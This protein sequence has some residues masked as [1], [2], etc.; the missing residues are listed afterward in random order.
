MERVKKHRW[1]VTAVTVALITAVIVLVCYTSL[2]Q[3]KFI[4]SVGRLKVLKTG[5]NFCTGEQYSRC[6]PIGD[7]DNSDD[8]DYLTALAEREMEVHIEGVVETV[9]VQNQGC[10]LSSVG[11][12]YDQ[13]HVLEME[14]LDNKP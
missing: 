9:R 14:V 12:K 1:V 11:C 10:E 5:I 3:E 2:T 13:L 6:I 4:D 8:G 7:V